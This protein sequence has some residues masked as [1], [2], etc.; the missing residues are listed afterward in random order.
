MRPEGKPTVDDGVAEN[1]PGENKPVAGKASTAI[2]PKA[3]GKSARRISDKARAKRK[4]RARKKGSATHVV[5]SDEEIRL[6][7]Y[8]IS[9]RRHRS[10]V[11][12]DSTRDWLEARRQLQKEAKKG[13]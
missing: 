3:A 13:D 10:G 9:E 6:R 12:G 1:A 5:I 7:A 8:F 4:P 11:P 2:R